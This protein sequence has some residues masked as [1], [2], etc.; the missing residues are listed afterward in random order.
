MA[1][2]L[3]KEQQLTAANSQYRNWVNQQIAANGGYYP[4]I[5]QINSYK[6]GILNTGLYPD[7]DIGVAP[8][9]P[10]SDV[11]IAPSQFFIVGQGG[12]LRED[13]GSG[14][15]GQAIF[16]AGISDSTTLE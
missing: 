7:L 5:D 11:N 16:S 9:P 4:T 2:N 10:G 6:A 12:D 3:T 1:S 15:T 8:P 14:F 13:R